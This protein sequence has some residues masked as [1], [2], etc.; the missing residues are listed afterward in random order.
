[1][2]IYSGEPHGFMLSGGQ[3]R[4]DDVA[5]DAFREM[6]DFFKRTLVVA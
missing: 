1:M 6:A 4:T 5:V 3:L 2:K